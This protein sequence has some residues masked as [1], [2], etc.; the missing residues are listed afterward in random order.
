M[1]QVINWTFGSIFRTLGRIICYLLIGGVIALIM[2]NNDIKITDLLGIYTVKAAQPE[3]WAINLDPPI[4]VRWFDCT[5]STNCSTQLSTAYLSQVNQDTYD[6]YPYVIGDETVTIASNGVL[7]GYQSPVALSKDYMYSISVYHCSNKNLSGVTYQL[8]SNTYANRGTPVG[9]YYDYASTTV[10]SK[11]PY[12]NQQQTANYCY[13]TRTMFTTN[14]DTTWL[15]LKIK[16]SSAINGYV[17][18]FISLQVEP[19]GIKKDVIQ[20]IITN[21]LNNATNGL[22][23][24]SQVTNAQ[25]NINNNITSAQNS[26]NST[27]QQA[28]TDITNAQNQTTNAVNGIN[29]NINND[30]IS[31]AQSQANS[32]FNNFNTNTHGLT[33]IITAPL[34]AI[35]SLTSKT[36]S[37][38]VLPLPFVNQ[39]LTLPCMRSIYVNNFGSFM[40]IYDLICLGIVSYWVM[41]RI[42]TLVKDFKNPDH[43]EIE[44]LDL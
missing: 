32:F 7:L 24:S 15:W 9:D 5:S 18:A 28:A 17:P 19:M 2:S 21:A 36:C 44:V 14:Q 13:M 43:D 3:Q 33:G 27:T 31:G 42:F 30:N 34:N 11:Y 20:T 6:T 41:V 10:L 25:N 35:Q 29:N 12:T 23:T 22:A 39:N 1:K 37:P 4:D 38:L 16:S 40:Q 26:I 8:Y